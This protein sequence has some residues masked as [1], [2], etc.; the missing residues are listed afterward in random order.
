MGIP[1]ICNSGIGDVEAIVNKADA[2]IVLHHFSEDDFEKAV[3]SIP[4]LVQRKPADIRNSVEDIYSLN[5]GIRL[6]KE[7]YEKVIL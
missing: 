1:V 2:G 6:Y 3:N 5:K 7:C 4:Y